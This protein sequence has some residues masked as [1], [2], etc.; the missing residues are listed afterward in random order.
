M[1]IISAPG[2]QDHLGYL[3][4]KG[5]SKLQETIASKPNQAKPQKQK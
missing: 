5:Q 1:P 4:V 2:V 3:G